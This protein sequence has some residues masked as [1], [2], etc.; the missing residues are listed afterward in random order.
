MIN[1]KFDRNSRACI[2]RGGGQPLKYSYPMA[3]ARMDSDK[4][5]GPR[6]SKRNS[7]EAHTSPMP[8]RPFPYPLRIGTDI[9]NVARLRSLIIRHKEDDS[10]RVLTRFLNRIF[11][12]PEREYFWSR[13]GH[14]EGVL[15]KLDAASQFLAGRFVICLIETYT[16]LT[17]AH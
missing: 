15:T 4:I 7:R 5:T 9:C 16:D 12:L 8:P 13:F 10:L 6:N 2:A 14:A 3:R 11:T 1:Q 17:L